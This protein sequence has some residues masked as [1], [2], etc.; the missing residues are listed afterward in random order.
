MYIGRIVVVV[1]EVGIPSYRKRE[2]ET[3][4]EI[5]SHSTF[6]NV[7][8]A[9]PP[10]IHIIFRS[11]EIVGKCN[12]ESFDGIADVE[13]ELFV[14]VAPIGKRGEGGTAPHTHGKSG[15]VERNSRLYRR[16]VEK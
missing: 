16:S 2:V 13:I 6:Q 3:L 9:P 4:G 1:D 15:N 11:A 8:I 14:G 5:I 12:R 7:D 10:E